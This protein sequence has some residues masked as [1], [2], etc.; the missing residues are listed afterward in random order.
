MDLSYRHSFFSRKPYVITDV[1]LQLQK[2]DK[3]AITDKMQELMSRRRD[4]QPLEYPSAGSTFKRPEG[5][6]AGRLIE[7]AGMQGYTVGG[8]QVSEKHC[9][10][11]VNKGNADFNDVIS[12]IDFVK[13]KV[14]ETSGRDLECE[15]IIW[16]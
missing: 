13:A 8:A 5:D 16:K 9:G 2:G 11:V 3:K 4:K 1:T 12:V 10:F 6:F 7:A 15:V 14:K